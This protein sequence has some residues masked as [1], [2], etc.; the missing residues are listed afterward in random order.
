METPPKPNPIEVKLK[1]QNKKYKLWIVGLIVANTLLYTLLIKGRPLSDTFLA[2]FYVNAIGYNI[3][4]F[5]LGTMAALFPYKN[6][7]Y[8]KKYVRA[9]LLTILVIQS[10]MSCGLLVI[11]MMS[12]VG[13]Y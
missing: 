13:W 12:L 6:Q 1:K 4:G 10:V 8:G 5:L 3:L 11:L 2:A 9:S 7:A